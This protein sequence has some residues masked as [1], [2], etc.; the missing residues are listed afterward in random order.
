MRPTC[1][2]STAGQGGDEP[3]QIGPEPAPSRGQRVTGQPEIQGGK[4]RQDVEFDIFPAGHPV[5]GRQLG[6]VR[7]EFPDPAAQESTAEKEHHGPPD[8]PSDGHQAKSEPGPEKKTRRK[9]QDRDRE[10]GAGKQGPRSRKNQVPQRPHFR[11]R[12]FDTGPRTPSQTPDHNKDHQGDQWSGK[13]AEDASRAFGTFRCGHH[14]RDS[15]RL[16]PVSQGG[17]LEAS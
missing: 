16:R 6:S 5:H 17:S 8:Q 10:T 14:E 2:L 12:L 7:H 15:T 4:P 3:R 1:Q 11:D 13:R 9:T